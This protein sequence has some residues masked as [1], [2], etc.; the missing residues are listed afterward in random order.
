MKETL[1]MD[2]RYLWSSLLVKLL[3]SVC[4]FV[5]LYN[6]TIL[7][8]D[9]IRGFHGGDV[10][11][12]SIVEQVLYRILEVETDLGS[13]IVEFR[14]RGALRSEQ[15]ELW[16]EET[17]EQLLLKLRA[18][19]D[20]KKSFLATDSALYTDSRADGVYLDPSYLSLVQ[21]DET[22]G[23]DHTYT[24][25]Q[26][27][28]D[29]GRLVSET[30]WGTAIVFLDSE[31]GFRIIPTLL[32]RYA[33][34]ET[35]KTIKSHGNQISVSNLF[36]YHL[37]MPANGYEISEARS[38]DV[39]VDQSVAGGCTYS[40]G[41]VT[42]CKKK[43]TVVWGH[44][45]SAFNP[46]IDGFNQLQINLLRM[47]Y[48]SHQVMGKYAWGGNQGLEVSYSN[49]TDSEVIIFN[50]H[51]LE[52]GLLQLQ[53]YSDIPSVDENVVLSEECCLRVKATAQALSLSNADSMDCGVDHPPH[54]DPSGSIYAQTV[55]VVQG[56]DGEELVLPGCYTAGG[57]RSNR[58]QIMANSN[59]I[60]NL[61][62]KA[63]IVS[64]ACHG[65]VCPNLADPDIADYFVQTANVNWNF[66]EI[67][68]DNRLVGDLIGDSVYCRPDDGTGVEPWLGKAGN[69][70]CL[71]N[72]EL[73]ALEKGLPSSASSLRTFQGSVSNRGTRGQL[74]VDC[75]NVPN[76]DGWMK[77]N[78]A[79]IGGNPTVSVEL[80]PTIENVLVSPLGDQL[81][82]V[83]TSK[84]DLSKNRTKI[85]SK[86]KGILPQYSDKKILGIPFASIS[87]DRISIEIDQLAEIY[88]TFV[89][90]F[91]E[92][93]KVIEK[94]GYDQ[95]DWKTYIE[96]SI[97]SHSPSGVKLVGNKSTAGVRPWLHGS[98]ADNPNVRPY[99][100]NLGNFN[101]GGDKFTVQIPLRPQGACCVPKISTDYDSDGDLVVFSNGC[102]CVQDLEPAICK[103]GQGACIVNNSVVLEGFYDWVKVECELLDGEFQ[104]FSGSYH[105]NHDCCHSSPECEALNQTSFEPPEGCDDSEEEIE[106]V[107]YEEYVQF[108]ARPWDTNGQVSKCPGMIQTSICGGAKEE[109]EEEEGGNPP[110]T[111]PQCPPTDPNCGGGND[112]IEDP[113]DP[114]GINLPDE[115]QPEGCCMCPGDPVPACAAGDGIVL[116]C[117]D[118]LLW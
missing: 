75:A 68:D 103:R 14:N 62:P 21:D 94:Y 84:L 55:S 58:C 5:P 4:F 46:G 91:E 1:E 53:C 107:S 27:I 72:E 87:Q 108:I 24:A 115:D 33:I 8:A 57:W 102:L 9:S 82:I 116:V 2:K 60:R 74:V 90:R 113:D 32:V 15:P 66:P 77:Y 44:D 49:L 54:M 70:E 105:P 100:Y 83:A 111:D 43:A 59:L 31:L 69:N 35:L 40:P 38:G 99:Q 92:T 118:C 7:K 64:S 19:E 30:K 106:Y 76:S 79:N 17:L 50:T 36:Y 48:S 93:D 34:E 95:H 41:R 25:S 23:V 98:K 96:V 80:A 18:L 117:N 63:V 110:F 65:G 20:N 56:E 101:V 47:G 109:E 112:P 28:S 73:S 97:K 26:M 22:K 10:A 51:G 37:E 114:P 13:G 29:S 71:E 39:F 52:G 16:T 81:D 3:V 78:A 104:S 86:A 67:C 61:A 45:N 85:E 42:P 12:Q 6:A 11:S 88:P 89:W